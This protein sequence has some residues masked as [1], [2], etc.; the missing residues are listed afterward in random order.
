MMI[1]DLF[2]GI[3][4]FSLGFHMAGFETA[5]A[6]EIDKAAR[7]IYS[8]RFPDVP[9]LGDIREIE[10][11]MPADVYCGGFPCQ[12]LSVAGR[13][14]GLKGERSGLFFDFVR[15]VERARPRWIVLENV[16]GLLSASEGR[17]FATVLRVLGDVGYG[18]AWRVLDA[19]FFGV[20]QRRRRVWIV[21]SLGDLR[22]GEVLFEPEDVS[23]NPP[24]SGKT[25]TTIAR[26]LTASTG[27][28]SGK[29]Q[30]HTFVAHTLRAS[31]GDG[32]G[33]TGN[34]GGDTDIQ[35][36]P[37]PYPDGVR[38]PP[39][40]PRRVDGPRYR[41]LGNAVPVPVVAWIAERIV[42]QALGPEEE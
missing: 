39:G 26:S 5:W 13:R 16:P 20:P 18:V 11:P 29:E 3:G 2:A 34:R 37:P 17:D 28:C 24:A 9:L 6:C 12:N 7:R 22:C 38:T 31:T 30:Q 15:L 33:W 14:R 1:A 19:Q 23:G 21:G 25:G 41:G 42:K 40:I 8:M 4:G 27:G 32:R 36:C 35:P 10:D